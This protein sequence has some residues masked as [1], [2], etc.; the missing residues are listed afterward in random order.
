V[1][2]A[3]PDRLVAAVELDEGARAALEASLG[4]GFRV[5]AMTAADLAAA[6]D[7]APFAAVI[8]PDVWLHPKRLGRWL[9]RSRRRVR[10]L[11]LGSELAG[12]WSASVAGMHWYVRTPSGAAEVVRLS[13]RGYRGVRVRALE[14]IA[15]LGALAIC[16][17]LLLAGDR[18]GVNVVWSGLFTTA[19]VLSALAEQL[20]A[21]SRWAKRRALRFSGW[22]VASSAVLTIWAASWPP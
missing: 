9:R 18:I 10:V 5:T 4:T 1:T 7:T 21:E 8:A 17:G 2:T 13:E 22:V 11:A 16:G 19:L 14:W 15:R 3:S 6:P 20:S 12:P